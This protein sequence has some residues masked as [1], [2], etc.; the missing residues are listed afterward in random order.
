MM[1]KK[2]ITLFTLLGLSAFF[3]SCTPLKISRIESG[4]TI[5][6]PGIVFY[7]PQ[8]EINIVID[9]EKHNYID[10]Q[11]SREAQNL[12]P[13]KQKNSIPKWQI[14]NI[15]L[16]PVAQPD[17]SQCYLLQKGKKNSQIQLSDKSILLGFNFSEKPV[18]E[19]KFPKINNF[20]SPG[21]LPDYN[22]YFIKKNTQD[23]IDTVYTTIKRDSISY[24]KRSFVKKEVAKSKT[25]Y[26][27]DIYR[28]LIKVR[29]HKF[30]LIAAMDDSI[31]NPDNLKIRLHHLDSLEQVLKILISGKEI[32]KPYTHNFHFLPDS[33]NLTDTLAYFSEVFGINKQS[34]KPII[35][36]IEPLR[37]FSTGFY[38]KLKGK[39][40][41]YKLPQQAVVRLFLGKEMLIEQQIAISQLGKTLELPTNIFRN[42]NTTVLYSPL[43]GKIIGI[44]GNK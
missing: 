36:Q 2:Y 24:T 3:F 16:F 33:T 17:S 32:S 9:I 6:K 18:G 34:G 19:S 37:K 44:S 11:F 7:L 5:E 1:K 13:V 22:D 35:I 12:L 39:G 29:K 38:D 41:P 23:V 27:Y 31:S 30:R 42:K 26:A 40:L 21:H 25:D 43:T 14:K 28:Y 20:S 15:Q 4:Q 8:T 10:G